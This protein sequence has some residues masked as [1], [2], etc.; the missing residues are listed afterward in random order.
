L[1]IT[2]NKNKKETKEK[3]NYSKYLPIS[4]MTIYTINYTYIMRV[5]KCIIEEDFL[6]YMEVI[7]DTKSIAW[8]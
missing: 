8:E 6:H 2:V 3:E 5:S 4:A 7:E 1:V